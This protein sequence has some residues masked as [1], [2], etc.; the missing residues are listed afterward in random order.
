MKNNKHR[1]SNTTVIKLLG[2][3]PKYH[4]RRLILVA[5][6]LFFSALANVGGIA[7]IMPFMQALA[8][9]KVIKEQEIFMSIYKLFGSPDFSTFLLIVGVGVLI[10]FI[11]SNLFM[12][13]SVYIQHMFAQ[14][15]A[16]WLTSHL[17]QG[18]LEQPYEF[19]LNRNGA[20]LSKNI[21]SEVGEVTNN[22]I[23]PTIEVAAKGTLSLILL[24]FL[25]VVD[26]VVAVIA[27]AVLGGSYTLIFRL[28]KLY[29][30]RLGK[31]KVKAN[32]DRFR[33]A[34]ESF[35]GIKQVKLSSREI[36]YMNR[37]NPEAKSFELTKAKINILGKLPK[38]ALEIIAL[39]GVLAIALVLYVIEGNIAGVLPI[40]S[41]YALAGYR[42]MPALQT[43]FQSITKI[44]SAGASVDVIYE[45]MKNFNI[46][47]EYSPIENTQ[48]KKMPT[49]K[50]KKAIA[51]NGINYK[52]P[53]TD[54]SVLNDIHMEIKKNT[55]IGFVGPTG[56]GKTTLIDILL[57]LLSPEKGTYRVD[58][59]LINENNVRAW[60]SHMGYVPQDIFLADDTVRRNVSLGI[61]E[62]EID[63]NSVQRACKVANIDDFIRTELSD[64][65]ETVV[66]E[67]G[68]RLSGGQRQRIGIA[69]ALYHNPDLLILDEATSALDGKTESAIMDAINTLSHKKT[70]IMIAHRLT[71]LQNCDTIYVLEKGKIV[72]KGTYTELKSRHQTFRMS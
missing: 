20:E 38:F 1:L 12:A 7:S 59:V 58:D 28:V 67:R 69:R 4:K 27:L 25:V 16:Y 51:L 8:N 33:I 57:G 21:F 70:I 14:S 23:V 29:L 71:T 41:L 35:G 43:M 2:V 5:I 45:D 15:V 68:I 26:P 9:P 30:V 53:E 11:L 36:D 49:F 6:I 34:A 44:R 65:Y 66:G 3:L 55:T 24:I 13:F 32:R 72:D 60:Q 54:I 50:F 62:E 19:F 63:F 61:P 10:A 18:Y 42:L 56:C 37:F 64:G 22:V 48:L 31:E 39:G 17:M 47:N 46:D 40:L 52:Y